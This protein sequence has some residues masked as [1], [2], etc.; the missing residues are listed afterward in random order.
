MSTYNILSWRIKKSINTFR[1]RRC[2]LPEA[3]GNVYSA[4]GQLKLKRSLKI[5][6]LPGQ[7]L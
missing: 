2:S 3:M 5:C 4:L 1:F 6:D 7:V